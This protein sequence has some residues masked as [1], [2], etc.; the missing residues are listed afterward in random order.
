MKAN[1]I[2]LGLELICKAYPAAQVVPAE[3]ANFLVVEV[4][5]QG[6]MRMHTSLES[7]LRDLGFV[8]SDKHGPCWFVD[9]GA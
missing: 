6:P 4:P 7:D 5:D 2:R 3:N 9:I 1:Q 8:Y